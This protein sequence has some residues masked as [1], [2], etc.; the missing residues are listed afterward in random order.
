MNE[1]Q[2][3]IDQLYCEEVRR[4]RALGE[5]G[6]LRVG[7]ETSEMNLAWAQEIEPDERA[8]RYRIARALDEHGCYGPPVPRL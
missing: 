6:R 7:I 1:F 3:L 5:E 2:P 4:A 8:R